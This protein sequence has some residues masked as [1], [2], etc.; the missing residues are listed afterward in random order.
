MADPS[1]ASTSQVRAIESRRDANPKCRN[2]TLAAQ[3]FIGR[4][5]P[6]FIDDRANWYVRR[7]RRRFWDGDLAA[8]STLHESLKT[9]TLLMAPFTPFITDRVWGDMF[10]QGEGEPESVH[11]AA[12]PQADLSLVKPGLSDHVSLVRRLVEL[13][14]AAR[15]ES[16][17]KT[18]Q[19]LRRA[20]VAAPGW[21]QL[22]P[23]LLREITAELNV[24]SALALDSSDSDLVE[25]SVKANFRELGK[26]FGKQT[27]V[28]A[29]AVS[30]A[31]A[32]ELVSA[33]RAN[34]TFDIPL[35]GAAVS[36]GPDDVVI[37]ETP[38]QGW[39]VATDGGETVALDLALDEELLRIGLAR[40]VV[41][42]VQEAR[43]QRGF[44]VTDRICLE[45]AAEGE[46]AQAIREQSE[47]LAQEVL[48]T[49]FIEVKS[50]SADDHDVSAVASEQGLVRINRA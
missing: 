6:A 25:V 46:A 32:P 19:P 36:I 10:A 23:D 47:E 44:D 7:S 43:K 1:G 3:T 37:T 42:D 50:L 48:A 17:V 8:L 15:A 29:Q 16:K 11:L 12:W 38:K 33:L 20:L 2:T 14:R 5:R 45:W 9:V 40:D 35:E 4:L 22:P 26:R 34:G 24:L 39:A 27:P 49:S 41:R 18:R 28:V 31:S 30:Q 13:G 21:Q